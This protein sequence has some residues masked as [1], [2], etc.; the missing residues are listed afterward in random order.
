MRHCKWCEKPHD[1]WS[2]YCSEKC[3]IEEEEARRKGYDVGDNNNSTKGCVKGCSSIFVGM[4]VLMFFFA[5]SNMENDDN[6]ANNKNENASSQPVESTEYRTNT[7]IYTSNDDAIET[8]VINE[9]DNPSPSKSET[10][11]EHHSNDDNNNN[12]TKSNND[13]DTPTEQQE[14]YT[15]VD[16]MPKFPGGDKELLEYISKNIKYP[17]DAWYDDIQGR[18][19]VQVVITKTGEI[20]DA[21]VVRSVHPDLDK[22]ALRVIKSLPHFI[23]GLKN[24][25]PVDV[26]YTIPVTFKI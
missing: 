5:I 11:N 4:F 10:D 2:D 12:T 19:I 9:D 16:Q 23:P 15:I 25:Q 26:W 3:R 24:D 7:E 20:G 1:N 18:V 14:I 6:D 13:T 21:K 22:E 17:R 8:T